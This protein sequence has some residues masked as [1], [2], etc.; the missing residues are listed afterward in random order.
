[1]RA[2]PGARAFVI[3]GI[4][5][6]PLYIFMGAVQMAI[7]PGFDITRHALSL[8][9]NGELGWL[10]IANFIVTGALLLAGAIGVKRTLRAGR[11]RVWAPR[12]LGLYGLGLIGAGIFKADPALGFPP[13]TPVDGNSISVHGLLHLLVGTIGFIGFIS[14]CLILARRFKDAGQSDWAIFSAVTGVIFLAAF[15]G[16]ASGSSGPVSLYFALALALGF[17]WLSLALIR[18][19]N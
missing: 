11:G 16:I 2:A 5:A 1:V 15:L 10:Q 7:R 17:V 19:Q 6:G 14:C 13:G 9:S 8:L 18:L 3:A 4:V 12:M